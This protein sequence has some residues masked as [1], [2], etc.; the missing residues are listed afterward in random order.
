MA[1]NV[2]H[3]MVFAGEIVWP[4]LWALIIFYGYATMRDYIRRQRMKG[5]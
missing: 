4:L 5:R 3:G 2:F 1:E